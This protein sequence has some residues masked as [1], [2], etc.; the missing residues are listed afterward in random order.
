[1]MVRVCW[2]DVCQLGSVGYMGFSDRGGGV[3]SRIAPPPLV[4]NPSGI[5]LLDYCAHYRFSITKTLFWH[6]GV[7]MCTWHKYT[8]GRS[9]MMDFVVMS[10]DLRPYVLG[11]RDGQSCQPI[12]VVICL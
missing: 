9:L 4:L 8:C 12:T 11:T 5:L 1:M 6:K 3:I 2:P 10:L 7:H